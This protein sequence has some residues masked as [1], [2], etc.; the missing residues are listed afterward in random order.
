MLEED[1]ACPV[2]DMMKV[3][4]GQ[5]WGKGEGEGGVNRRYI[6]DAGDETVRGDARGGRILT[7]LL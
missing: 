6:Q 2:N 1:V 7:V 4:I 3:G 5:Y